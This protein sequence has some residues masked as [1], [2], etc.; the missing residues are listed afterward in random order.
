MNRREFL[1]FLSGSV[2]GWALSGCASPPRSVPQQGAP[3]IIL[4]MA[5]DAG[6][7]AFRC[8]GG[9]SCSTPNIDELA[10]SGVRFTHCYSQPLCTPSRVKLMT[11]RSNIRNYKLFSILDPAEETFAPML[12][13]AGYATAAAGKW[14]L[15]GRDGDADRA[16]TGTHP[17]RAGFDEYCLWQID[18]LGKRY[19]NPLIERNGEVMDLRED[20]YG[21]D[22]FCDFVL[23]FMER[24]QTRPFFIYYPMVLVHSPFVPTPFSE[25]QECKDRQTN[26]A[27]MVAY[28]DFNVVRIVDQLDRLGLRQNTLILFTCD[29]GTSKNITSM[30]NGAE[31][32][33][34]KGLTTDAGTHVPLVASWP[35]RGLR[36]GVCGDLIDF[37][38]FM[39]TLAEASGA[40]L[41]QGVALD[42]RSFLPQIMGKQG[43]PREW[44][45]C[46]H[47]PRPSREETRPEYF[48]RNKQWKL[49]GDGRLF[50]LYGDPNEKY[51]I[52]DEEPGSEAARARR[53]LRAVIDEYLILEKASP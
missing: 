17:S 37:S 4:I 22:V 2:G 45:F 48:A 31:V 40:A 18:K 6:I 3:N 21:P 14:Q 52:T 46:Y 16:G 49:Y 12:W 13:N 27:D 43:R 36:G 15:F 10:R 25:D 42:G 41:P 34:G 29:N 23:D 5:D 47:Y 8:Y 39:P 26:F 19:W 11:G 50:D 28:M 1:G 30:W 53:K 20:D 33:G 9:Q 32:Q 38:D 35:A 7:D 44:I 24:N 51:P